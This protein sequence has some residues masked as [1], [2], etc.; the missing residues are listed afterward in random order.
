MGVTYGNLKPIVKG[1]GHYHE[2]RWNVETPIHHEEDQYGDEDDHLISVGHSRQ[3]QDQASKEQCHD[4]HDMDERGNL[5]VAWVL[6][7]GEP[8]SLVNRQRRLR[9]RRRLRRRAR[10]TRA[11]ILPL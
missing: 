6:L 4:V 2:M 9:A 1:S 10:K 7:H 8:F 11:Y 5:L 3:K